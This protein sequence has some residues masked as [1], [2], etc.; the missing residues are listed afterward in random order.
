V[1]WHYLLRGV[2]GVMSDGDENG[3]SGGSGPSSARLLRPAW[4]SESVWVAV[5]HVPSL[6][7]ALAGLPESVAGASGNG[8]EEAA[9][10]RAWAEADEPHL[11]PLPGAWQARSVV[12]P[13]TG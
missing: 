6:S 1:E 4:M 7:S 3:G 12:L 8:G 13:A 2:T 5:K 10:W 9:A 11:L